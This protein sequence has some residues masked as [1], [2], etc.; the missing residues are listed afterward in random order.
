MLLEEYARQ[1]GQIITQG[2]GQILAKVQETND[3][4][5]FL[6]QYP[7]GPMYAP[8]TGYYSVRYGPSALERTEDEILNGS[9]DRLFVRRLSDLIT[10]RDPRGG[11]VQVTIDPR[12]QQAAFDAMSQANRGQGFT[13]AVVALKPQTGEILAMVSTPSFDPNQLATHDPDAQEKAWTQLRDDPRKPSINRAIGE[14]YPPGSTFKLVVAAAAL[15]NGMDKDTQLTAEPVITLPNTNTQL[16]NFNSNPCGSGPTA[17]L[18]TALSLSCNTAFAQLAGRLGATKL[19]QQAAK[20]GIGRNDLTI[21]LNVATSSLGPMPDAT[22]C[23]PRCRTP[24]W[25]RRSP[26][27]AW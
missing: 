11:N 24:W 19:S 27:A 10:G 25:P 21:P 4:L 20:F 18:E 12:V 16:T 23:S 3:R 5:K 13:G 8:V 6:R 1:R 14:I 2:Q 9:D 15:E 22:C 26:T 7:N 17:S